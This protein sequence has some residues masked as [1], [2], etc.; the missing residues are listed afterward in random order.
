MAVPAC[1]PP[2][3][4]V[5]S[6]PTHSKVLLER[7]PTEWMRQRSCRQGL[8][9]SGAGDRQWL[10]KDDRRRSGGSP[11]GRL[12]DNGASAET[13]AA[14][15]VP[16]TLARPKQI[17]RILGRLRRVVWKYRRGYTGFNY[18]V[19][20]GHEVE[21]EVAERAKRPSR[22]GLR[23]LRLLGFRGAPEMPP[24]VRRASPGHEHRHEQ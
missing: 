15:G 2:T 8:L 3:I 5:T 9:R 12:E 24:R 4:I 10:S 19:T 1:R 21:A 23:V 18:H 14:A 11:R 16:A 20:G 17:A 22:L 13:D 6:S 7:A